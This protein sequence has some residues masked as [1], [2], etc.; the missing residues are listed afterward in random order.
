MANL[1]IT[2]QDIF[3]KEKEEEGLGE[4]SLKWEIP[5]PPAGEP[6]AITNV[7]SW[8]GNVG[9]PAP[10]FYIKEEFWSSSILTPLQLRILGFQLPPSTLGGKILVLGTFTMSTLGGH[11]MERTWSGV[12]DALSPRVTDGHLGKIDVCPKG[13][14]GGS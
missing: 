3:E 1:Q 8:S 9:A 11:S 2:V 5:G 4:K 6:R 12:S 14:S 7:G 13:S 10:S